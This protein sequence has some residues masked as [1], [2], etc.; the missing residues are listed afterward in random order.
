MTAPNASSVR[1]LVA[2]ALGDFDYGGFADDV[3]W[4]DRLHQADAVLQALRASQPDHLLHFGVSGWTLQHSMECRLEGMLLDCPVS[5][6]AVEYFADAEAMPAFGWRFVAR[7]DDGELVLGD[8]VCKQCGCTDSRACPGGCSWA[9]PSICSTCVARGP[10]VVT[11]PDASSVTAQQLWE[12]AKREQPLTDEERAR[13]VRFS[14]AQ[15]RR[16]RDL[17]SQH[18][19]PLAPDLAVA[20]A[21]ART[22]ARRCRS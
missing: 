7:V 4:T 16:F 8:A 19:K 5:A 6:A 17:M 13:G 18:G 1:E 9:A 15:S 11:A 20:D 12:Q 21:G 2:R 10:V 3:D 14:R 22:Q